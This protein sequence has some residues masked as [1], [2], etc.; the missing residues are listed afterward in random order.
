[1]KIKTASE[2]RDLAKDVIEKE[3][4]KHMEIVA[5]MCKILN[6]RIML[7]AT[8]NPIKTYIV[9]NPSNDD[10]SVLFRMC[11]KVGT[12]TFDKFRDAGYSVSVSSTR[13]NSTSKTGP[14][15]AKVTIGW[16]EKNE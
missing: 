7:S 13:G 1:M 3:K 6:E 2:I 14:M 9:F 12:L 4:E 15:N 5:D 10:E 8:R 11:S 16:G